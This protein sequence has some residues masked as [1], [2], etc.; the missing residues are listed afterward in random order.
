MFVYT[1]LNRHYYIGTVNKQMSK[2]I[3]AT[4]RCLEKQLKMAAFY[5][6][7]DHLFN[8]HFNPNKQQRSVNRK[9]TKLLLK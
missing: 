4:N 5:I 6:E 7:K 9:M 1:P 3:E 2:Q 8:P